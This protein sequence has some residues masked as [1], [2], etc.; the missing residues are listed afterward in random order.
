MGSQTAVTQML[1]AGD[2]ILTDHQVY[3]GTTEFFSKI[4]S[5]FALDIGFCDFCELE[6][7]ESHLKPNT[8]LVWLEACT[9][10][11]LRVADIEKV[12]SIVKSKNPE[13]IIAVDNTF[14][15]PYFSLPLTLGADISMNSLTK[16]INGHSDVIMG[17]LATNREDIY[18]NL[19]FIQ[20]TAGN[21]P[22]AFDSFL[23]NRGIKTLALRMEKHQENAFKIAKFLQKHEL[24][25]KVLYPGL[26]CHP[27]H[28]VAKKQFSGFGGMVAF[29]IRGDLETS[30]KFLENLQVAT[31]A[32]SLGDVETLIAI[33]SIMIHKAIPK[34]IREKLGITDTMFRLSVGIEDVDDLINDFD[35]A[36][37]A[38]Q[39]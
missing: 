17:M 24:I 25:E 30:K 6:K 3:G 38:A 39:H 7:L 22:S 34:D 15:T 23:V 26:P 27:D 9:N 21:V 8:K 12:C 36:L 4:A 16:Y 28:E 19:K 33:P 13:A 20:Y 11:L 31:L 29:Y 2:H 32:A 18:R 5:K 37:K 35:A 14:A 10:P 1:K